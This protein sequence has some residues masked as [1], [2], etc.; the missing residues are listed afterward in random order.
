MALIMRRLMVTRIRR[1]R[2]TVLTYASKTK[3]QRPK[4]LVSALDRTRLWQARSN[5]MS[6]RKLPFLPLR[7][8]RSLAQSLSLILLASTVFLLGSLAVS[9]QSYTREV[10]TGEKTFVTIKSRNGRI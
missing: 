8:R 3:I 7:P 10:D 5:A 1:Y 9:A 6:Y 2:V 4:T